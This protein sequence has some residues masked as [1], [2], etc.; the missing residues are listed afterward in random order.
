MK[1]TMYWIP[2][3]KGVPGN[4]AADAA[5][6]EATGW[7]E[8]GQ[9]QMA[10]E[11]HKL[12]YLIASAKTKIH[13]RV[14]KECVNDWENAKHGRGT[15]KLTPKPSPKTLASHRGIRRVHNSII[16][17]LRT[18]NIALASYLHSI[19]SCRGTRLQLWMGTEDCPTRAVGMREVD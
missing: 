6:K 10:A 9:G 13:R 5:A 12:R 7:S 11:P 2:A 4:E 3:H 15:L 8:K 16:T 1:I 14:L 18:G 19:K 17:Q